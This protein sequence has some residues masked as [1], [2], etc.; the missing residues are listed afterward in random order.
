MRDNH[1]PNCIFFTFS[2]GVPLVVVSAV[3]GCV[4]VMMIAVI[5]Q[6][7][8]A[9]WILAGKDSSSAAVATVLPRNGSV[10][11]I[12]TVEMLQMRKVNTERVCR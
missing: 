4:M 8:G 2:S 3:V 5:P 11:G 7:S 9:V 1:C 6:M 12:K 10:M